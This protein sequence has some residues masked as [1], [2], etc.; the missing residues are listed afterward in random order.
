MVKVR[1]AV[2][3]PPAFVALSG[4]LDVAAAV[5]MPD[6]KPVLVLAVKPAGN[7]VAL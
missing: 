6:I 7:P 4:I 1:V 3:V 5:G 2:P